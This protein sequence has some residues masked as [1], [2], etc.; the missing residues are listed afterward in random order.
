MDTTVGLDQCFAVVLLQAGP[1]TKSLRREVGRGVSTAP[2]LQL[3]WCRAARW[4]HR[5]LPATFSMALLLQATLWPCLAQSA[6]R[7]AAPPPIDNQTSGAQQRN[8]MDWKN[9]CARLPS[10]RALAGRLPKNELLPLR[11]FQEFGQV[12]SA[13]FTQCKTGALAKTGQW[14]GKAPSADAF[15][16]TAS[17]YFITSAA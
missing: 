8:F 5:A 6:A 3:L 4:G 16:N 17:G 15:F 2:W 11:H 13:F 10:N 1:W 9:A 14:L 12:V 7:P